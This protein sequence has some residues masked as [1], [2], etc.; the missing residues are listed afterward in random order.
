MLGMGQC[1]I[2]I[3]D[4]AQN[5]SPQIVEGTEIVGVNVQS[6]KSDENDKANKAE[7]D[8][9][10]T[11]EAKTDEADVEEGNSLV[12]SENFIG[13]EREDIEASDHLNWLIGR[14]GQTSTNVPFQPILFHHK[15]L[16]MGYSLW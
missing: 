16:E 13:L 6:S 12:E 5:T 15:L 14:S 2:A 3:P 9:A 1:Q 4:L 10:E 7:T 11:D 8:E